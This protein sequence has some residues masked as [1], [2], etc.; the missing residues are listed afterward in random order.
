MK[1]YSIRLRPHLKKF[2]HWQFFEGQREPYRVTEDSPLGK[3]FIKICMDKR[4]KRLPAWGELPAQACFILSQDMNS[5]SPRTGQLEL[6][7]TDVHEL[8]KLCLVAWINAQK[9]LNIS[10]AESIRMF[11]AHYHLEEAEY[12]YLTALK[13]YQRDAERKNKKS[14][15]YRNEVSEG[16]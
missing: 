16:K 13:L 4:Q 11:L 6:I 7:N 3:A 14:D 8:F 2:I 15:E 12:S 9:R 5:Y 10:T 1:K